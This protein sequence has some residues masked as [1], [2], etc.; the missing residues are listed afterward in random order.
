MQALL[1]VENGQTGPD[2]A[3]LV[4]QLAGVGRDIQ[5]DAERMSEVVA[6][7]TATALLLVENTLHNLAGSGT[8]PDPAFPEQSR[9]VCARLQAALSGRLL[10][11]APEIPLLDKMARE[12]QER[13]VLE[14]VV[15]EM[16]ANLRDI[17]QIGRAHV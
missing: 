17:E 14:Q 7:E 1:A 10:R 8:A 5:A 15:A 12:A 4:A 3:A 2:L 11:T 9:F 16:Q 13:L 6:L